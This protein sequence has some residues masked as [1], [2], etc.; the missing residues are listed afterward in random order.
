MPNRVLSISYDVV[1]LNTRAM[2]L[3]REGYTVTSAQTLRDAIELLQRTSFDAA[4]IGHSIPVEEQRQM[5][6]AIRQQCPHA[7]VIALTRREGE[8]LAFADRAIEA[9]KPEEMVAELR[10]LLRNGAER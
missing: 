10:H 7:P 8:R 9:Q 4:I 2:I 6:A 5:A 3:E 1:L